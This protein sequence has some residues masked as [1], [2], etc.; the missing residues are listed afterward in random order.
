MHPVRTLRSVGSLP[1]EQT[2]WTRALDGDGEG[3]AT[4]FDSHRDR[5]YRHALWLTGNVHDAEDLTAGAFLELWRRR[6]SVRVVRW[7]R[8][9]VVAGHHD[10]P[11]A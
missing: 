7:N 9:A 6:K 3:F 4:I 11:R 1:E 5:V 2:S 10:E 8:A